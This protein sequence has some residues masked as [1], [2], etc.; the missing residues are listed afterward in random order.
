MAKFYGKLG[1]DSETTE[2]RPGVWQEGIVERAVY[3]DLIRN[4]KRTENPGQ[5]NDNITISNQVS[6]VA[7]PYARNNFHRI[8]Y[9][10][11]MG[12]KWS[13]A[14]VEVE[15]PR[16]VLNLGGVYNAK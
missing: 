16:L 2:V 8:K 15:F 3:G 13:V 11:F 1:Y 6:F 4:T 5:V 9:V 14:S 10:E 7:D 12:A